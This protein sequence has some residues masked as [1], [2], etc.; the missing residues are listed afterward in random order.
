V[1]S[2]QIPVVCKLKT[3]SYQPVFTQYDFNLVIGG[4]NQTGTF[5]GGDGIP[6]GSLI[7]VIIHADESHISIQ[8]P[9]ANC[10]FSGALDGS[11]NFTLTLD[12]DCEGIDDNG[13][14]EQTGSDNCCSKVA[15]SVV[16]T[17]NYNGNSITNGNIHSVTDPNS[18]DPD[19][20]NVTGNCVGDVIFVAE[21][22]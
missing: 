21:P 9:S 22:V 20:L 10:E 7:P 19:C 17:G 11:G 13:C 5:C 8:V 16:I 1:N 2:Y 18:D 3:T 15:V 12:Q 6:E 14:G 4:Q